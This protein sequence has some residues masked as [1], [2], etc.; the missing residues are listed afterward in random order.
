MAMGDF[1]GGRGTLV[2]QA[3][4]IFAKEACLRI[5]WK[6]VEIIFNFHTWHESKFLANM[7]SLNLD[8]LGSNELKII[9]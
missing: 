4:I 5:H 1:N 3:A 2:G 9:C 7:F 8:P 6:G